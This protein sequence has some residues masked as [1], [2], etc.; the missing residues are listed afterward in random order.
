[1]LKESQFNVIWVELTYKFKA[2]TLFLVYTIPFKNIFKMEILN[3]KLICP[4]KK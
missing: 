4:Y 3:T 2:A 1:M